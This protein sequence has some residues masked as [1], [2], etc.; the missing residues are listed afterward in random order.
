MS[1]GDS[2]V[3]FRAIPI[4]LKLTRPQQRSLAVFANALAAALGGSRPLTCLITSDGRLREL[5]RRFLGHDYATDVLSFPSS[6]ADLLGDLAISVERAEEQALRYRH[7]RVDEIRILMLHGVLHLVGY[8]HAI[9]RGAMARAERKW[10]THFALPA[11]L[12]A[13]SSKTPLL[14]AATL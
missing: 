13:R 11:T 8:D 10:R 12:I 9:D 7:S 14:E 4:S 1:P 6:E 3:L 5:N 2:T